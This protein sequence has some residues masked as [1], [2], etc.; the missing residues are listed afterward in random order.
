M[1]IENEQLVK[2]A[3]Q[4]SYYAPS[5]SS[6]EFD[7]DI[8]DLDFEVVKNTTEADNLNGILCLNSDSECDPTVVEIDTA[9]NTIE[10]SGDDLA[11]LLNEPSTSTGKKRS[12]PSVWKRNV[13]KKN[14]VE[15]TEFISSYNKKIVKKRQIG[16]DCKCSRKCF[17]KFNDEE[18]HK[19]IDILNT[20]GSKEKQ[21]TYICGLLN[22]QKIVRRRIMSGGRSNRAC[23]CKYK[24]RIDSQCMQKSILLITWHREI[25]SRKI[26]KKN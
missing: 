12:N 5:S 25:K 3:L 21:D 11:E 1:D 10:D 24:I 18:K 20:I 13:E 7:D 26:S 9:L 4:E 2:D 16:M 8:N 19:T 14:R 17:S 22:V 23:A 15:G 6:E